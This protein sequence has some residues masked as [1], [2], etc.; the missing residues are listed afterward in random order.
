VAITIIRLPQNAS[1]ATAQVNRTTWASTELLTSAFVVNAPALYS[2]TSKKG[3]SPSAPQ[4][5][6]PINPRHNGNAFGKKTPYNREGGYDMETGGH[7]SL[8][9]PETTVTS[10]VSNDGSAQPTHQPSQ[11]I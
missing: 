2:L 10:S 4:I 6:Q 3:S 1:H 5:S 9:T 8:Q 11:W 7:S